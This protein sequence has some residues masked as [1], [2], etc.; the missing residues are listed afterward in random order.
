MGEKGWERDVWQGRA[1]EGHPP[2]IKE[3]VIC[4]SLLPSDPKSLVGGVEEAD[5]VSSFSWLGA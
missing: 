1:G 3:R 4:L 2:M 5:G